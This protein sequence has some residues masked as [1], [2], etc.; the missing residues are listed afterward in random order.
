MKLWREKALFK[1]MINNQEDHLATQSGIGAIEGLLDEPPDEYRYEEVNAIPLD[2]N[3]EETRVPR[4]Q[5]KTKLHVPNWEDE[6]KLS[7]VPKLVD[8]GKYFWHEIS[9]SMM[10]VDDDDPMSMLS[11]FCD[12][13]ELRSNLD[14][15]EFPNHKSCANCS[16]NYTLRAFGSDDPKDVEMRIYLAHKSQE[17]C[18]SDL[19]WISYDVGSELMGFIE[20]TIRR[21][22]NSDIGKTISQYGFVRM[23]PSAAAKMFASNRGHLIVTTRF[24]RTDDSKNFYRFSYDM[25]NKLYAAYM[26]AMFSPEFI[27]EVFA[28]PDPKEEKLG[29]AVELVEN[30]EGPEI[31]NE[32]RRGFENS[33][34]HFC[35]VIQN[36]NSSDLLYE[37][38][39]NLIP[40]MDEDVESDRREVEQEQGPSEANS[41]NTRFY[42][43]I[44]KKY[45]V[46]KLRCPPIDG[47]RYYR[48][49]FDDVN[50]LDS[51]RGHPTPKYPERGSP[52]YDAG[53]DLNKVLRHCIGK[54]NQRLT[55]DYPLRCDEGAWVLIEDLIQYDHI[56]HDG[57]DYCGAIRDNNRILANTIKKQRV[58]WIVTVD[59][60]VAESNHKGR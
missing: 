54:P 3:L 21:L 2:S 56:W 44:R 23:H 11:G 31:I 6:P 59:L 43:N 53:G 20:A 12:R 5:N 36:P 13:C 9:N 7:A 57:H 10:E 37:V 15:N 1:C 33:L 47:V 24:E 38:V 40:E 55:G 34:L 16:A 46:G 26:H 27:M 60:A 35:S 49:D 19:E 58:G 41:A 50:F 39:D 48:P 18:N 45:D 51:Y 28:T 32:M 42:V 22:I 14:D 4:A 29:D 52:K 8:D 25:G 17:E 30:F